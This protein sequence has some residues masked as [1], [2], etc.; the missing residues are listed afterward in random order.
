MEAVELQDWVDKIL[1]RPDAPAIAHRIASRLEEER[2]RREAFYDHI[3][4]YEKAEFING[5]IVIHSPVKKEH[6][7]VNGAIYRLISTYVEVHSFGYVG[8]EKLMVSLQRNDYEPDICFFGPE[9]AAAFQRGQSLFPAPDLVVEVL[10]PKTAHND[11]TVKYQDYQAHGVSEYWIVDPEKQ[12]LEQY[13]LNESGLYELTLKSGEG[14]LHCR[15]LN[16]YAFDIT[17][18]FDRQKNLRA[19]REMLPESG[20]EEEK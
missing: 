1:D 12:M 7:D 6:N 16:D 8:I 15:P 19:M 17:A 14:H 13:Q 2:I 5:Q 11:R 9:K 18:F 10:S 20:K 4:E 3:S